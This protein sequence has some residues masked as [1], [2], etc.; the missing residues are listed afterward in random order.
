V[1][2]TAVLG[3]VAT[4]C[5]VAMGLSPLLQLRTI[6]ERQSSDDISVPFFVVLIFGLFMWLSYGIA[7]GN[8]ALIVS[9]TVALASYLIT[10]AGVLH[11]RRRVTVTI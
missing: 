2:T 5:G 4:I 9:N 7:L 10:T 8:A 1:S 3:I 11:Y 6:V